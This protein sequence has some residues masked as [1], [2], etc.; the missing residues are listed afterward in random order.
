MLSNKLSV[1]V[2]VLAAVATVTIALPVSSI[3]KEAAAPGGYAPPPP[4][5]A[6]RA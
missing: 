4:H 1:A 2:A 6:L 3:H 5:P